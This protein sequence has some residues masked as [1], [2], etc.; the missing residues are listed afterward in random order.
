MEQ[1]TPNE[2]DETH[3]TLKVNFVEN[4]KI[5]VE[6]ENLNT[7]ENEFLEAQE[8]QRQQ[9]LQQMT[10]LENLL[11]TRQLSE[12]QEDERD[13]EETVDDKNLQRIGAHL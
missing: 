4:Q 3:L 5:T 2:H 7:N 12:I 11:Q 9:E 8:D 6:D 1:T 10:Q 13:R